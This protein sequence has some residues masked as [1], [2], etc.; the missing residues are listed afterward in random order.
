VARREEEKDMKKNCFL[1]TAV[2]I[3]IAFLFTVSHFDPPKLYFLEVYPVSAG[4]V[5]SGCFDDY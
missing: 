4:Y 1:I 2:L 5:R 3:L